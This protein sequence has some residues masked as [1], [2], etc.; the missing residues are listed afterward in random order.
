MVGACTLFGFLI[1]SLVLLPYADMYGRHL[2][3]SVFLFFMT[4]AMWLF[5]GSMTFIDLY[6]LVCLA[7]FIGGAVAIPLISVMIC[8]ATELSTV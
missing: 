5:L 3:N 7:S 2:M 1:G 8:Y 6:W 4:L